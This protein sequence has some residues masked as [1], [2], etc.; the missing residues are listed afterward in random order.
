MLANEDKSKHYTNA[1]HL[2]G[3]FSPSPFILVEYTNF[4]K[5]SRVLDKPEK[6]SQCVLIR[7]GGKDPPPHPPKK[8]TARPRLVLDVKFK[9]HLSLRFLHA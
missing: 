1:S 7:Y 9:T 8:Q 6:G 3:L 2:Q 5:I 4:I